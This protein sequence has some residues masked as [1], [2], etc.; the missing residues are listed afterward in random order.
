MVKQ[1]TPVATENQ[2]LIMYYEYTA[3]ILK[4]AFHLID[5]VTCFWAID[6]MTN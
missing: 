1:Q 4:Q 3:A 6:D 2:R 5:G